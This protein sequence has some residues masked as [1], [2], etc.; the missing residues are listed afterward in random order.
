MLR[1]VQLE[2][3]SIYRPLSGTPATCLT[4]DLPLEQDA[5]I[6][7]LGAGDAR[8]ILFTTFADPG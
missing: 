1:P 3:A 7:L 8:S 4:Q 5:T 6:L 2:R